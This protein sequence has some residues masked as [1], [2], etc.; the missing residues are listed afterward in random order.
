MPPRRGTRGRGRGI[1]RSGCCDRGNA[2]Q[3]I[4]HEQAHQENDEVEP[5]VEQSVA[6]GGAADGVPAGA[7]AA[8]ALVHAMTFPKWMS[9]RLDIFDGSGTPTDAAD[10][11]RK[12]E[13]VM[14]AC[15]MERK[16]S[17]LSLIS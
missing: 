6:S 17:Y 14:A 2:N 3:E 7:M 10:W 12:M 5:E 9:M 13:K 15:R 16:W 11:L 4:N 1:G 8:N